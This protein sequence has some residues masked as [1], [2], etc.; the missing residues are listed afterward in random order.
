MRGLFVLPLLS[1][2]VV[3]INNVAAAKVRLSV[4]VCCVHRAGF[5]CVRFAFIHGVTAVLV[6]S[7]PW[8]ITCE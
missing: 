3:Y 7:I 5:G 6:N 2:F 8:P 4:A 1:G